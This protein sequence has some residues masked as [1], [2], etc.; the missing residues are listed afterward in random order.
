M[1]KVELQNVPQIVSECG[2]KTTED[3]T[4][5][6]WASKLALH[7]RAALA[8]AVVDSSKISDTSGTIG[9]L[10]ATLVRKNELII[11]W[12]FSTMLRE[13][14]EAKG[15]NKSKKP[16]PQLAL[17]RDAGSIELLTY[18][19]QRMNDAGN[20]NVRTA[21]KGL[22]MNLFIGAFSGED[23]ESEYIVSVVKLWLFVINTSADGL[24][25]AMVH[26]DQLGKLIAQVIEHYFKK[27]DALA[28][29][30]LL[31]MIGSVASVLQS[32]CESIPNPRKTL[33]LFDKRFLS[34]ILRFIGTEKQSAVRT[35][36][37]DM[38]HAGLFHV[39]IMFRF[40]I[41][42]NDKTTRN[43][44]LQAGELSYITEKLDFI[45]ECLSEENDSDLRAQYSAAMPDVFAR[46][47]QAQALICS[48]TRAQAATKIGLS[49]IAATPL[50]VSSS[51]AAQASFKMFT[52][53]YDLLRQQPATKRESSS[54]LKA[55]NEL[56]HT[57]YSDVC[58]GTTSNV[59]IG[60]IRTDQIKA[61][62]EWLNNVIVPVLL[63]KGKSAEELVITFDGVFL[64]LEASSDTVQ[65]LG[66]SLFQAL[67]A[68]PNKASNAG[69]R[70]LCQMVSTLARARQLD[71]IFDLLS[72]AKDIPDLGISS[73]DAE[74]LL[75][76]TEFQRKLSRT[77]S[78]SMPFMQA[79]ATIK[80]ISDKIA[81]LASKVVLNAEDGGGGS[82]SR[83]S[84]KRRISSSG[85]NDKDKGRSVSDSFDSMIEV[86]AVTASNF[87]LSG[88][89]IATTEQ[90]RTQYSL[91]LGQSYKAFSSAFSGTSQ[92]QWTFL[93]LHYS[94][95]EAGSRIGCTDKWLA[96]SMHPLYVSRQIM[97]ESLAKCTPQQATL[98]L[99]VAFQTASHWITVVA[100]A[101]AGIDIAD[102]NEQEGSEA[103]KEMVSRV[104]AVVLSS[105]STS[106]GWGPWDGQPQTI[107]EA[108]CGRAQWELLSSS[109]ELACEF[110][111]DEAISAIAQ[112]IVSQVAD[113]DHALLLDAGFFEI[114]NI[115]SALAP[116]LLNHAIDMWASQFG[117]DA[118]LGQLARVSNSSAEGIVDSIVKADVSFSSFSFPAVATEMAAAKWISLVRGALRIPASYW[119]NEQLLSVFVFAM[120]VDWRISRVFPAKESLELQVLSRSL[121]ERI[122]SHR[123]S[124]VMALVPNATAIVDRWTDNAATASETLARATR[125]LLYAIMASLAQSGF[126]TSSKSTDSACRKL[127]SHLLD[128]LTNEADDS[129]SGVLVLEAIGAVAKIAK[130]HAQSLQKSEVNSKWIKLT[131][132]WLKRLLSIVLES[133]DSLSSCNQLAS[134]D[135]HLVNCTGVFLCLGSLESSLRC[136]E[137]QSKYID[138]AFARII[139]SLDVFGKSE[140]AFPMGLIA[141]LVHLAPSMSSKTATVVLAIL[142]RFVAQVSANNN[143][144]KTPLALQS[145]VA[146][147]IA[148]TTAAIVETDTAETFMLKNVVEP[149]LQRMELDAFESTFVATLRVVANSIKGNK[150]G[151]ALKLI[152]SLICTAY[153]S[154]KG[155][156][157]S[158]VVSLKRKLVQKKLLSTLTILH[159]AVGSGMPC[160]EVINVVSELAHEPSIRFKMQDVAQVISIISSVVM[161]P[162]RPEDPE[163]LFISMCRLLGAIIHHFT[164]EVLGSV[165]ILTHILRVLIHAF[166]APAIPRAAL[167]AGAPETSLSTPW[168]VALAPLSDSCA[169]AYSRVLSN[170]TRSRRSEADSSKELVK[171]TKGTNTANVASILSPIV[172]Y[173]LAEYCIVQGGGAQSTVVSGDG[174]KTSVSEVNN[175]FKGLS[176]RPSLVIEST[177]DSGVPMHLQGITMRG[178]ISSPS[179]REA[180]LPGWYS[181]LDI[182]SES[183]RSVLLSLLAAESG[184]DSVDGS[185]GLSSYTYGGT[186][187]FGP[188]EYGGAHEVLKS[189]YQSYLDFY[190]F[191]GDK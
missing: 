143:S 33:A 142:T 54:T 30:S 153:K 24:E 158:S 164:D 2:I 168:V 191:K 89:A 173:V 29:E 32:V 138:S 22:A 76:S 61:L 23:L 64:A 3:V 9:Y 176:W 114:K 152:R 118:A 137:T 189:L 156:S 72:L 186:S 147:I 129:S 88:T 185:R 121:L 42:L 35:A 34:L 109:L 51:E 5:T 47:L 36:V 101:V 154:P 56:V 59:D 99:A 38:L 6:L 161:L 31:Q 90:Q 145:L 60:N 100:A 19:L 148:P 175:S 106:K 68:V 17:Y 46:Y 28:R 71:V 159:T 70:L 139:D 26:I 10:S 188:N 15:G 151:V 169:E 1:S 163:A 135:L 119:P 13:L 172:P 49:A 96:S 80:M 178:I 157:D 58:F 117:Q 82:D 105:A 77:V 170:L 69:T 4:Q 91:S 65:I 108:N 134:S 57:Y 187:I 102:K 14:K 85:S 37:L 104:I 165:A 140:G 133:I 183:D 20:L 181:L 150:D 87:A 127:C 166:V 116:A 112:R 190:K 52:F 11:D 27:T 62:A 43:Q 21:L 63:A 41:V 146:Y 160:A 115:R 97:P 83:S 132:P 50:S 123:P 136:E 149:L 103:V 162:V 141:S 12:L 40:M 182:I 73:L 53:M 66:Q 171:L 111:S 98:S 55:I 81:Q 120:A 124:T 94:F 174:R 79:Q 110:A 184:S 167:A 25:D 48:E 92:H 180:L 155:L 7:K 125:H 130:Q 67:A 45:K 16:V 8:W 95:I 75:V 107:C 144:I 86:L 18:I 84:K 44:S 122:A 78:Q 179:L 74:N 39:D 177:K 131:K 93:L 113:G 126:S 128:K